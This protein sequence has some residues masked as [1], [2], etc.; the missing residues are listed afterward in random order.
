MTD[1]IFI[2][3]ELLTYVFDI[4]NANHL[5]GLKKIISDFYGDED[6]SEA[7]TLFHAHYED[8]VGP[9]PARQKRAADTKTLKEKEVSDILEAMKKLDER[10]S[11][12]SVKFVAINLTNL[13]SMQNDVRPAQST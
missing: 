7:K 6:V 4:Y 11:I 5:H 13:P 12:R 1:D 8:V 9:K 10:G 2:V 3:N